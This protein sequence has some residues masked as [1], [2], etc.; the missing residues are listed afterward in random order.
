MEPMKH[1]LHDTGVAEWALMVWETLPRGNNHLRT[2]QKVDVQ[3][4]DQRQPQRSRAESGKVKLEER[5]RKLRHRDN[6]LNL[7]LTEGS[8]RHRTTRSKVRRSMSGDP[9]IRDGGPCIAKGYRPRDHRRRV[10]CDNGGKQH[11]P[12]DG[13]ANV[14]LPAAS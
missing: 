4:R 5:S 14:E 1:G 11:A 6:L 12:Q 8:A 2:V 3:K 13:A 9:V 10:P 7:L